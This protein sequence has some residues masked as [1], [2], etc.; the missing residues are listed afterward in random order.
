MMSVY[1]ADPAI[2]RS[3]NTTVLCLYDCIGY[4][5]AD[6]RVY[7]TPN[8][9]V[10]SF[11]GSAY[12]HSVPTVLPSCQGRLLAHQDTA[13]TPPFQSTPRA[14]YVSV[15]GRRALP[16]PDGEAMEEFQEADILWPGSGEQQQD[17]SNNSGSDATSIVLPS[18]LMASPPEPSAPVEIS[19]RK[20]RCRPWA[21]DQAMLDEITAVISDNDEDKDDLTRIVPPH[22]LVARRRLGGRTAAY[23]MCA[24]KGRTLKGRDLR[25]VRNR[26]LK[27]TGF[28]E[29]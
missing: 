22:V 1:L 17:I 18:K 13:P 27:M 25:D 23:S 29:K 12:R 5:A 26:V 28:I 9:P 3:Y 4:V 15:H 10:P 21:S 11:L 20:R 7:R 14:I 2:S 6:E 24:G 8:Q 16:A 19:R